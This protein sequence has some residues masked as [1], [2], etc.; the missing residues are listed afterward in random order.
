LG[1]ITWCYNR[2]KVRVPCWPPVK[3]PIGVGR[4]NVTADARPANLRCFV[5]AGTVLRL[6]RHP[7]AVHLSSRVMFPDLHDAEDA[8]RTELHERHTYVEL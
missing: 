5:P 8:F 6:P 7:A 2:F 3:P 4:K 1:G